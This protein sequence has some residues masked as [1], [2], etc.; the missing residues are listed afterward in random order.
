[1]KFFN[2]KGKKGNS[3]TE[4]SIKVKPQPKLIDSRDLFWIIAEHNERFET[5]LIPIIFNKPNNDKIKCLLNNKI[6]DTPN[7]KLDP[8]F[9]YYTEDDFIE[10][11][12]YDSN[13]DEEQRIKSQTVTNARE[14]ALD[15]MMQNIVLE[16]CGKQYAPRKL[17]KASSYG[18][19]NRPYCIDQHYYYEK[20]TSELKYTKYMKEFQVT[21]CRNVFYDCVYEKGVDINKLTELAKCYEQIETKLSLGAYVEKMKKQQEE[22]EK[23]KLE[24]DVEKMFYF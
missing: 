22:E 12:Y 15:T 2:K 24:E 13:L 14:A 16:T 21:A 17:H 19:Y 20:I 10:R 8:R 4:D 5:V 23:R 7:Y 1:M 18:I 6:Y 11:H 3:N 9:K